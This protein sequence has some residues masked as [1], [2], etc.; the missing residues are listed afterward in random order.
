MDLIRLIQDEDR[1]V[2]RSA[3]YALGPAFACV[4]G[5]DQAWEDLVRLTQDE[6]R[7]VRE[8]AANAV[9]AAFVHVSN[10]DH[11]WQDL[12]RMT[13]YEDSY[14]RW[15]AAHAMV[16]AFSHVPDKDQAW[17]DLHGLTQDVERR[18]R[19]RAANALG[20]VFVHIPDKDQAW[21]DLISL[22]RDESSFVRGS[23]A[24]ALGMAYVHVPDKDR[25]WKDLQRLTQDDDRDVRR[26]AV[27]AL[28]A[29]FVYV[30]DKGQAG[31]DLHR[32]TLDEDSL[33]RRRAADSLGA[34]F[35]HV[36]D[37]NQAWQ[38]LSKL[39]HDADSNVRW[40]ATNSLGVAFVHVPE[41]DQAWKDLI[42]LTL[43]EDRT[44]R[45]RAAYTLRAAFVH[46]PDKDQAWKDLI[47]LT[48]DED[49]DVQQGAA[50]AL[51]AAFVHVPDKDQAWQDLHRMTLDKH[52]YYVRGRAADAL[53]SA[54][55]H[56]PD[57]DQA[58]NDLVKLSLDGDRFVRTFAYHSLGRATIF[59]ATRAKDSDALK[60]D[61]MTAV[62]YFEKSSQE[63]K[64]GPA[65]FCHPF[66]RTYLAITFQD[67]KED[68]VQ[69]YLAE[70]KEAIGSS[71]S[72]G[73]LI[74]AVENLAEALRRSRSLKTKSFEEIKSEL[75]TY[76]WYCE[77][78]AE[79]M[80]AAEYKA[81]GAVRLMRMCNPLLEERIQ[82]TIVE[83]QE[84]AKQ[85]CKITHGSGTEFEAPGSELQKAA[86]GLSACDISSIQR[87]SSRIVW[88]LKKLC[89][90]LPSEDREK[91]CEIVE[92]IEHEQDFP[93]KLNKIMTALLCLGPVLEAKSPP[94]VDVVILTVLP[95]EYSR[96]LAK[97]PGLSLPQ[98]M[99]SNPNICAW[100]FGELYSPNLN[101]V[102][103][104]A[105]GMIGRPG[106]S[107][108]ALAAKDAIS[109]WRPN[110]V[111]FS[112]IAGGLPTS[113]LKKGDVIIA[114][115]I[116]G[117]EYGKIAKIFS[118]RGNW[119]Y[120]TDQGLLT[121]AIAYAL[122]ESWLDHVNLEP[123]EECEPKVVRCEIASGEKVIDDPSNEFFKQVIEQWPK[124]KAV[125]M[126]GA[127]IGS[128]I[129]QAQSLRVPVGF[130][131]IRAISDLP[132][133]NDDEIREDGY[134]ARGTEE[135]D[136][137]KAY[138]SDAAAAFTIG[139][140]VDG[141]PLPPSAHR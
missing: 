26:R 3:A 67:A 63:S 140:I 48:L 16:E 139:W 82:G 102:Y 86:N 87:C 27:H 2:R 75:N 12:H 17:Q 72:K 21:K 110:Y 8:R 6:D 100:R 120:K 127:G 114:D 41:K 58:W 65:R 141:L 118:P 101:G 105:V 39:I 37:K 77:K 70:A 47:R 60:R 25:A 79:H 18:V 98:D 138:A 19:G 61:L 13:Q 51:G 43:D 95:E 91:V 129:E 115:C 4:P 108:G 9:G 133:H 89:G 113:G 14:V 81:P 42:G 46:V 123:P 131:V 109:R 5:K 30:P 50:N 88:Q 94:L 32:L 59:M 76:R 117:Y 92:E 45:W 119:T 116:Y 97:L 99:A 78:A 93:E 15:R 122:Q 69:R 80:T 66:Y 137:W 128:A 49:R 126:E 64:R 31:V 135:R 85:I 55:V 36:L 68:E 103:K 22:T 20:S 71:K 7:C 125:E 44:V 10:K 90:L 11:A 54:F 23:A 130:M 29:A 83:I 121:G 62:T 34:A 28:G 73:D 1:D 96:V 53:G 84:K 57:R 112:G 24:N 124:V 74:Q 35:S 136:A 104:V 38:D 33:V 134:N 52:R 111:I 56:V 40:N 132:R 107:Q 106:N